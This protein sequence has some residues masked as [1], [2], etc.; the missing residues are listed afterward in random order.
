MMV[1]VCEGCSFKG[2]LYVGEAVCKEGYVCNGSC[3][4]EGCVQ[5]R[6]CRR[7]TIRRV[8]CE[9]GCCE[10]RLLGRGSRMKRM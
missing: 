3:V 8:M 9:V 4:E 10:G 6:L 5:E 1:V 2:M 7:V